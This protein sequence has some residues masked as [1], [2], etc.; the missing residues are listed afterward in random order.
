MGC[1]SGVTSVTFS[2]ARQTGAGPEG[3][4]PAPLLCDLADH[5]RRDAYDGPTPL[6][7]KAWQCGPA[8]IASARAVL[9]AFGHKTYLHSAEAGTPSLSRCCTRFRREHT[10]GTE[11]CT[12]HAFCFVRPVPQVRETHG[13]RPLTFK[14]LA[15][16]TDFSHLPGYTSVVPEAAARVLHNA[17]PTRRALISAHMASSARQAP[18]FRG[19]Q[20]LFA[21][22]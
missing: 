9:S 13:R 20:G 11:T 8:T 5:S 3:S 18:K 19:I 22:T 21:S 6:P 7:D 10:M 1:T 16:R 12:L 2:N 14:S 17:R 4:A 15:P